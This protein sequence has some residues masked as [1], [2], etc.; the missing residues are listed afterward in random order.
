MFQGLLALIM[1]CVVLDPVPALGEMEGNLR[2]EVVSIYNG[3]GRGAAPEAAM[4]DSKGMTYGVSKFRMAQGAATENG[5]EGEVLR[6]PFAER[7]KPAGEATP[8]TIADPI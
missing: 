7:D 3:P 1:F 4:D 8:Q 2:V 5:T 6:D